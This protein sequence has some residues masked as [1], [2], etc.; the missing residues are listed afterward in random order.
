MLS[1]LFDAASRPD[2]R[3]V[4][5]LAEHGEFSITFDASSGRGSSSRGLSGRGGAKQGDWMEL[6]VRGLTFD[7]RGLAPGEPGMLLLH[8]RRFGLL[9]SLSHCEAVTLAPTPHL[10]GGEGTLLVL[11]AQLLLGVLLCGLPGLAAVCW[12]PA[13][14][15]TGTTLFREATLGWLA[16][17]PVPDFLREEM[18]A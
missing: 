6:S 11:R 8:P 4:R 12:L 13:H 9:P 17:R 10:A 3:A 5:A 14:S 15:L 16:G 18:P 1:L 2:A 7:L